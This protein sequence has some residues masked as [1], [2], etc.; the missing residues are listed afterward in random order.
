M[1]GKSV[2]PCLRKPKDELVQTAFGVELI[3]NIAPSLTVP[4]IT[5]EM[6][7]NLTEIAAD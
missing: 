2:E 3:Y 6:E 5:A 1:K 4:D 7:Y